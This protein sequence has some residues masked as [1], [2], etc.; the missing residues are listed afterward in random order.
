MDDF[1]KA[2]DLAFKILSGRSHS[3]K[4]LRGKLAKKKVEKEIEDK[5]IEFLKSKNLINDAYFAKEY[6][7]YR[8]SK[9]AKSIKVIESELRRKDVPDDVVEKV[10][11]EHAQKERQRILEIAQEK[12]R[13]F[14]DL[15]QDKQKSRLFGFLSRQG[16]DFDEIDEVIEKLF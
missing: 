4:E 6:I 8:N 5:V 14:K 3:E 9:S 16:Y 7:E 10:I 13:E 1:A 11:G 15:P 2:K 12:L